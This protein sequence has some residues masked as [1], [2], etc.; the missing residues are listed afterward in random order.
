MG[1]L[2]KEI[3][4]IFYDFEAKDKKV[5]FPVLT[6]NLGNFISSPPFLYRIELK[7]LTCRA[8]I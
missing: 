3:L 4:Y 2:A 8:Y 1:T 7:V 6:Y 5:E